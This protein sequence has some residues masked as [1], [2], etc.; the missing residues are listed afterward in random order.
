MRIGHLHQSNY[1]LLFGFFSIL[2]QWQRIA[3]RMNGA[4]ARVGSPRKCRK[5]VKQVNN[6]TTEVHLSYQEGQAK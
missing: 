4:I 2:Q 6:Y 1:G 5:V 3:G